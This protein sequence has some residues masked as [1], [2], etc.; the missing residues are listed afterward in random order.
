[1]S[2]TSFN[3]SDEGT[4]AHS[5][6]DSRVARFTVSAERLTLVAAVSGDK[7]LEVADE[8]SAILASWSTG[9]TGL[10][11]TGRS[12]SPE[13]GRF[14]I[15]ADASGRGM[16]CVGMNYPSHREEVDSAL[17]QYATHNP[18][19]FSKLHESLVPADHPLPLS[20]N[21]S[22][23]FDWEVELG[24]V[25]GKPG[26]RINPQDA[27]EHVAGYTLVNDIT[28]RDVQRA[29]SQWFLGKNVH[30]STPVGPV[31]L[32][33]DTFGWPPSAR[34]RLSVNGEVKQEGDTSDMVHG[35]ASLIATISTYVELRVG[36]II[37]TGSPAGVGFT[38]EPPE[39]LRHGD[40]VRAELVGFMAMENTVR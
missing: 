34:L 5:Q 37:A 23:E 6:G 24:V 14:E 27:F 33:R 12:F 40:V 22:P 26:R 35:V 13:E 11:L 2:S 32:H 9:E 21:D 39:F 25:I 20:A 19:I 16:F 38:R 31:V 28:A 7:V 8:W 29:H 30:E 15:P 10:S 4:L 18:V 3:P 17:G 36:D 1:M